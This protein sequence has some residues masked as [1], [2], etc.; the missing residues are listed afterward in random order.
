M[1]LTTAAEVDAAADSEATI[2]K[3]AEVPAVEQPTS[4]PTPPPAA[5]VPEQP[6]PPVPSPSRMLPS[7]PRGSGIMYSSG[8]RDSTPVLVRLLLCRARLFSHSARHERYGAKV[9]RATRLLHAS[10]STE[11]EEEAVLA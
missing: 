5:E 2:R 1:R 10:A 7:G 9:A 8:L 6:K 3:A 4:E 11:G